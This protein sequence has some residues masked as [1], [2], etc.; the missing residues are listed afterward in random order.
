M[1]GSLH[2]TIRLVAGRG[3]ARGIL[4]DDFHHFRVALRHEGGVI[5]AVESEAR[6]APFLLC[7]AA[8][9]ALQ[10]LV[11]LKVAHVATD[12]LAEVDSRSQCTHQLDL[13]ALVSATA[14]RGT[15]R[16]YRVEVPDLVD[17]ATVATVERDGQKLLEWRVRDYAVEAPD[18]F[19]GL[20]LGHGFTGWVVR[21]M[22]PE[23]AE[24]ALVLRRGVFVSRGRRIRADLDRRPHAPI[25]GACWVQ[26]PERAP[27]ATRSAGVVRD[28][29]ETGVPLDE[30]DRAWL[31]AT[32]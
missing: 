5:R 27:L 20:G 8:G 32:C 24:A 25:T 17:G 13:A 22:A 3:E 4:H 19:A 15:D 2:R 23:E 14:A 21:E 16:V 30:E 10:A 28:Y 11:G 31:K 6:R 7:P 26:Q 12:L 18:R 9:D 1:T 29:S